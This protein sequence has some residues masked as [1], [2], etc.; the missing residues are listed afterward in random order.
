MREP[1][2]KCPSFGPWKTLIICAKNVTDF[3]SG[4]TSPA[5]NMKLMDSW[6]N[7]GVPAG[8]GKE[9]YEPDL[10]RISSHLESAMELVP[11]FQTAE[12]MSVVNGPITYTPDNLPMIGPTRA[13]NMWVAVGFG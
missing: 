4:L 10:D 2:E 13:P 6:A 12:I 8:F 11:C 5:E 9:L 3:S 1:E 7:D